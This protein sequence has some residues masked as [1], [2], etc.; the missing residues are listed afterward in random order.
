MQVQR[1]SNQNNYSPIFG[2][3][4]KLS[5]QSLKSIENSTKLT[6][7]EM[8]NLSLTEC[9]KL[10]TERGALKKPSKFKTWIADKYRKIGEYFG[11]IQ[12]HYNIYTDVD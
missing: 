3:K 11:L 12:K 10:M 9:N 2:M 7:D 6:Y 5:E 1:I 4:F 8:I